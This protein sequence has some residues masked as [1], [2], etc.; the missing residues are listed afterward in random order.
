[1]AGIISVPSIRLLE[2]LHSLVSG[3]FYFCVL[4]KPI[5][6]SNTLFVCI[7]LKAATLIRIKP[8]FVPALMYGDFFH[9]LV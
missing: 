2:F 9:N 8:G 4:E 3:F 5:L 7:G 6:S 1:M